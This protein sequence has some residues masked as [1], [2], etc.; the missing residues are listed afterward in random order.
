[1]AQPLTNNRN[2][3]LGVAAGIIILLV[4]LFSFGGGHN[5]GQPSAPN[6]EGNAMQKDQGR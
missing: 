4:L 6:G 5:M 2:T 1:M 3:I